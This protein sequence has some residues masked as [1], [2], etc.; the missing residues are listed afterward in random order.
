[1]EERQIRKESWIKVKLIYAC[2]CGSDLGAIFY[3]TSPT[4]TPFNC[5][6]SILGHE[7]F[8]VVTEVG[9]K[10]QSIKTLLRF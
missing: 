3:K 4:L 7:V 6:L 10:Y 8:G 2:V 5:F 9:E 1:M